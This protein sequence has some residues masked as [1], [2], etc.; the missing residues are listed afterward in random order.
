M[1]F[2]TDAR[3]NDDFRAVRALGGWAEV[4]AL[5]ARTAERAVPSPERPPAKPETPAPPPGPPAAARTVPPATLPQPPQ[6]TRLLKPVPVEKPAPAFAPAPLAT[7]GGEDALRLSADD[8]EPI[9]L[10]YDAASRRFVV[11]DRRANKLMVADEVFKRVNDLIGAASGGFGALD[12]LAI[13][14]KRGDLWVTSSNGD[15]GA[16]IHKLQLV[17]GRVLTRIDVP[18]ELQPATLN[19]IFVSD[20][21]VVWLLDSRGRRVLRLKPAGQQ[22]E[23]AIPF[24]LDSP[25]SM[26]LAEDKAY[27]AHAAGLALIDLNTGTVSEVRAAKNVVVTGVQRVRWNHGSLVA[28]QSDGSGTSRLVRFRLGRNGHTATA[29][30]VLDGIDTDGTALTISRDAVYYFTRGADGPVIRRVPLR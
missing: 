11:G 3:E 12:A 6:P 8:I 16:A 20:A 27:I 9:G 22:V 10:A 28:I 24:Q 5:V 30:D 4:E 25:S 26:A 18:P 13:D 21:G 17:S 1:G 2:A 19:D 29:M 14:G 23:R 15:R 7:T